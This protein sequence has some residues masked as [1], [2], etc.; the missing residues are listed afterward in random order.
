M[1]PHPNCSNFDVGRPARQSSESGGGFNVRLSQYPVSRIPSLV[2]YFYSTNI[3]SPFK[4]AKHILKLNID[5]R[6]KKRD[7]TLVNELAKVDMGAGNVKNFYSFA[8][9]YCSHHAPEDFPIYDSYVD[10]VLMHL[11]RR[12]RFC[13]FCKADLKN[14]PA[15]R[16][17]LHAFRAFYG[18]ERY[19]LKEI[20]KYLWQ[21]GK[22]HFPAKNKTGGRHGS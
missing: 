13:P 11:K 1:I 7:Y 12:D 14:Y 5:P 3:F 16:K 19:S 20:D 2:F 17:I 10:K 6:L 21:L 4:V 9:K 8:T 18:L 15:Y 22:K